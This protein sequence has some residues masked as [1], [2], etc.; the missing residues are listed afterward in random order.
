MENKIKVINNAIKNIDNKKGSD[1][2]MKLQIAKKE[3]SNAL[4]NILFRYAKNDE[5]IQELLEY[6]KNLVEKE[7]GLG[8]LIESALKAMKAEE[9]KEDLL[10]IDE[11]SLESIEE[12][13]QRDLITYEDYEEQ[14]EFLESEIKIDLAGEY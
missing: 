6:T 10:D 3:I 5:E 9:E 11:D 4:T 1:N 12:E 8:D 13:I 2:T 14:Q 7:Q